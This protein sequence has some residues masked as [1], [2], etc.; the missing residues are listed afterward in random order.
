MKRIFI[1]SGS[2]GFVV[3]L[4]MFHYGV[5]LIAEYHEYRS[6]LPPCEYDPDV[7]CIPPMHYSQY[8]ALFGP[9]ITLVSVPMIAYGF[10][11]WKYGYAYMP[12][13]AFL[14][15]VTWFAFLFS[16]GS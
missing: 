10:V 3:G 6:T 12:F 7:S 4:L 5:I 8:M 2:I 9:P 11:K 13:I 14:L 16:R 1:I 15:V